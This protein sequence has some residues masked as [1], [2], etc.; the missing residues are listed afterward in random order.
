MV[1]NSFV[2]R[3]SWLAQ[4][5]LP[6]DDG[7]PDP[8][9]HCFTTVLVND[10]LQLADYRRLRTEQFKMS[11]FV[12]FVGQYPNTLEAAAYQQE[13]LRECSTSA[14]LNSINAVMHC[15]SFIVS[16]N[17]LN[18]VTAAENRFS[19]FFRYS[20]SFLQYSKAYGNRHRFH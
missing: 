12:D 19:K 18:Y 20:F 9:L 6:L 8:F 5:P 2:Y 13:A 3:S 4:K 1:N 14:L 7:T 10:M 11:H 16:K 17:D 15:G